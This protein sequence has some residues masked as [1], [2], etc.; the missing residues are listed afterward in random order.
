MS[1]VRDRSIRCSSCSTRPGVG[2]E[3][4]LPYRSTYPLAPS[5]M[6]D[7]GVSG[8]LPAIGGSTGARTHESGAHMQHDAVLAETLGIRGHGD[9]E[10]EAYT[11]RP[12]DGT[13]RGGMIV[14]HHMPGYDV[15]TKEITRRFAT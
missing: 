5:R 6:R 15:A 3:R 9:D 14:I 11:A 4:R 1:R 12:M 13:P 7:E 10:I 2:R 8:A